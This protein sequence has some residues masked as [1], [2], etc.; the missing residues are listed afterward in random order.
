MSEYE[1]LADLD[2]KLGIVERHVSWGPEGDKMSEEEKSAYI[3]KITKQIKEELSNTVTIPVSQLIDIANSLQKLVDLGKINVKE[4]FN[5][6]NELF[7]LKNKIYE[8]AEFP[9]MFAEQW[10]PLDIQKERRKER[11]SKIKD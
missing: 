5:I 9:H 10:L 4:L 8:L 6:S 2:K 1:K 11:L 3:L 7:S